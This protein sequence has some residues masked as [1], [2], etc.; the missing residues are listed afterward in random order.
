MVEDGRS[1]SQRFNR[2]RHANTA[3]ALREVKGAGA[4]PANADAANLKTGIEESIA[5]RREA[6][7]ARTAIS[8]ARTR[9][10]NGKHQAALKLLEDYPPPSHPEIATTLSE[11]RAALLEIE[12]Q[13]RAERERIERQQRVAALLAEARTALLEQ[14]FSGAGLLG[15]GAIDPAVPDLPPL[16]KQVRQEEAAAR[17]RAELDRTL[18][19]QASA[20]GDLFGASDLKRGALLSPTDARGV[21]APARRTAIALATPPKRTR[22]RGKHAAAEELFYQGDCALRL[23]TPART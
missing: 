6:A 13:R 19:I 23:L 7:R 20:R 10:A 12:E 8:N 3:V 5:T 18:A 14:R 21:R 9:F 11:L 2:R 22:I 17:L 1:A 16:W 15:R 4:D